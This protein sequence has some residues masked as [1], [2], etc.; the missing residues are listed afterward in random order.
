MVLPRLYTCPS[1]SA[2]A[3]GVEFELTIT[4]VA[5]DSNSEATASV[6]LPVKLVRDASRGGGHTLG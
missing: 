4:A 1:V 6:T 2:R 5:A 3:W